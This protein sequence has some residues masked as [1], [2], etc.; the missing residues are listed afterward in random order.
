MRG[1]GIGK[2]GGGTDCGK[3]RPGEAQERE[4]GASVW[5]TLRAMLHR[6][7]EEAQVRG[8]GGAGKGG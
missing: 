6:G 3:E 4:G 8:G 1:G 7:E 2:G 5:A